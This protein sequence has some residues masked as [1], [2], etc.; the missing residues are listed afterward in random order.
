M[1]DAGPD[2]LVGADLGTSGLKV[3]AVRAGGELLA[4]AEARYPTSRP[5]AGASEQDPSDWLA[6]LRVTLRQLSD[7]V[8]PQRWAGL[9]LSGMIPTLVLTDAPGTPVGPAITWEDAR[10]EAQALTLRERVGPQQLYQRT[11][12]WLDG[13]YLLPM[14]IRR[15]DADP[16]LL[17]Q[18]AWA[19]GAKDYLFWWLTGTRATDPST[20]A[21]YGAY[22]LLTGRWL[23]EIL[24]PTAELLDGR[25][26]A[27]PR[28]LPSEH[29]ARIT[30]SRARELGLPEG[31]SITLGA[32]DSVLAAL[33]LG[34]RD[35]GEVAYVAGTST[36]ILG[37]TDTLVLDPA[38]RYLV[39]P[40]AGIDGWGLEMDLLATGSALRWLSTLFG[41]TEAEL[42]TQSEG[43][44]PATAPV[45]LP[46]LAPGEQ[47]ALW[48]PLLSGTI[49]GLSLAHERADV[50]RALLT[51]LILESRRCLEVIE[52][53][54]RH[55][56]PVRI[57]GSSA[58][59]R[60]FQQDLADASRRRVLASDSTVDHSA[61]G[62]ALIAAHDLGLGGG[63]P[64]RPH[65]GGGSS[66]RMPPA[67]QSPGPVG[68]GPRPDNDRLWDALALRHEGTLADLRGPR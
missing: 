39:T 29:R 32:A 60:Q 45:F 24:G 40:L 8:P 58:T 43:R 68:L 53:V 21:G 38:H 61:V 22:G 47:G 54:T 7:E 15:H 31:L 33:A 6:A 13:R 20:A 44:N 42:V 11:G 52:E 55:R 19:M 5:E 23:P 4:R 26:P 16:H 1:S 10:A 46:Y 36:V 37:V 9:G 35:P 62:A 50:G 2:V 28:I 64:G 25:L 14:L 57:A 41:C 51:G 63:P 3:V 48:D 49:T 30:P 34:V 56:G 67:D 65:R 27:L 17:E 66:L 18:A 59:S 12:Q